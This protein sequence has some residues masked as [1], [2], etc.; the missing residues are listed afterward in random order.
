[1]AGKNLD[2]RK[3]SAALETVKE[4]PVVAAVAFTPVVVGF[5]LIWWVTS[6]GWALLAAIA[7]VAFVG[8]KITH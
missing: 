7:M 4:S 2:K 5:A 3:A 6:F 1:M 8:Y